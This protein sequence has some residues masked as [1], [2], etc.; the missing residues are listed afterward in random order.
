MKKSMEPR[1]SYS[2]SFTVG[3]TSTRA[4]FNGM[5]LAG[6]SGTTSSNND[7]WFIGYSPYYT[8]GVWGGCDENQTL[9]DT[10]KKINNGGTNFHKDIWEKN[11]GG[12]S[13]RKN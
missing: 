5:S 7:V 6:K 4:R 13:S 9:Q 10:K 2:G 8:A 3:S 11:Y 1:R 12:N